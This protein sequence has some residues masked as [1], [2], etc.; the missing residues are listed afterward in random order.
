MVEQQHAVISRDLLDHGRHDPRRLRKQLC[1]WLTP[2][3]C[4][5]QKHGSKQQRLSGEDAADTKPKV[6]QQRR[7]E[8]VLRCE[9]AF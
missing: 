6:G 1:C 5:V 4:P 8:L 2:E 7:S 3:G 9:R